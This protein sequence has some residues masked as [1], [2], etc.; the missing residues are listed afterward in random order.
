MSAPV[1][2]A[3]VI[4]RLNVGGPAI[5]VVHLTEKLAEAGFESVLY[6]GSLGADEA[7]MGYLAT[8]AGIQV[9]SIPP[10]QREIRP[11]ADLQA[12]WQLFRHFRRTRPQIV[13]THTFKAG[14]LGRVAARLAGV[15]LVF[16]TF[17]GH[18]FH[19]YYSPYLSRVI[20][21][22]EWFLALLTTRIVTISQALK[23]DLVGYH[24]APADKI[25]VVPLG[26]D[27]QPFAQNSSLRGQLHQELKLSADVPLV[28]IVGRLVSV[29]NQ[30]LF[31][32]MARKL[33]DSGYN[34]NFVVVGGGELLANLQEQTTQL[35]M[36]ERVH[37]LG[38]RQDLPRIYADLDVAVNTSV[39][40]GTPVALIEAMAAG[41]GVVAT[42]VG[43]VPDVITHGETGWLAESGNAEQLVSGVCAA[44][45]KPPASL[46]KAQQHVLAVYDVQRLVADI[47]SL[48][49]QFL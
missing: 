15:P 26:F 4:A 27:L 12:L 38:W 19:G 41:V 16:H 14:A 42:A 36:T 39:N 11:W 23:Q 40:E 10:L 2:I 28:G 9:V 33:L 32:E 22:V 25:V 30:A 1:R 47:A 45:A 46:H 31:L 6:A 34:G 24:I 48:Y 29:K 3:R 13:H 44:L 17:H 8:A 20:V 7:D 18:V 5:H 49:R 43:G 37:F 35:G 21:W